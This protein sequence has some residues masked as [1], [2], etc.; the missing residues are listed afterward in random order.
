MQTF[1][2]SVSPMEEVSNFLLQDFDII[3]NFMNSGIK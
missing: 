1:C 2:S 3:L